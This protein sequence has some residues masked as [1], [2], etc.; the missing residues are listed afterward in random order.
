MEPPVPAGRG[1]PSPE[2]T[3][4]FR[5]AAVT[6]MPVWLPWIDAVTAS[7]AVTDCVP[8]VLRITFALNTCVPASA[9]MKV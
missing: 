9:A 3:S 1:E 6:T 2:T 4:L 5:A 7:V 8:A